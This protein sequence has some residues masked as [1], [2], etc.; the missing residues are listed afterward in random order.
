MSNFFKFTPYIVTPATGAQPTTLGAGSVERNSDNPL[1][2]AMEI[3]AERGRG[4]GEQIKKAGGVCVLVESQPCLFHLTYADL[5][6]SD[7]E[8]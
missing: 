4:W 7:D 2:T 5:F 3:C 6:G 8:G 1:M